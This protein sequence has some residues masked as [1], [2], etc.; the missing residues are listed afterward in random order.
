MPDGEGYISFDCCGLGSYCNV[1]Y[2]YCTFFFF[3][4]LIWSRNKL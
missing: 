3:N 2:N 1:C 4:F